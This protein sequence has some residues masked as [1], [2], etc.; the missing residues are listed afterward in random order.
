[1]EKSR[2]AQRRPRIEELEPRILYSA[3]VSPLAAAPLI[4]EQRSID[5]AGEFVSRSSVETSAPV[6]AHA[7]HELVFLDSDVPSYA[8]LIDDI[9]TQATDQRKIEVFLLDGNTTGIKQISAVLASQTDINAVHLIAYHRRDVGRVRC[10]AVP[11]WT[12][13]RQPTF[14]TA[15]VA[16]H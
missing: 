8:Q 13:A 4:A 10:L 1:M 5:S 9:R 3:D 2:P 7:S 15:G 14:V 16:R 6:A 11:G 12:S